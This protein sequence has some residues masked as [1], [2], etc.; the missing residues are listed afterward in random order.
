MKTPTKQEFAKGENEIN[1]NLS[2]PWELEKSIS[3]F[4]PIIYLYHQKTTL[5]NWNGNSRYF[6]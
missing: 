2:G 6:L 4:I 5:A 1:G 3:C